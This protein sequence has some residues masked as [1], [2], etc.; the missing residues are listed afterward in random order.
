MKVVVTGAAGFIGTH[1]VAGLLQRDGVDVVG[2]DSFTDYYD[3]KIKEARVE[4]LASP[5]FTFHAEDLLEA[6]LARVFGDASVILHLAGQAGVRPSWG[7]DFRSYTDRNILATQRLLEFVHQVHPVD[8][9]VYAS[10]SSV[11][12]NADGYP[13]TEAALPRPFSPYGVTKLAAEHLCGLYAENYDVPTVSL[14]YFT[15]YGPGQRPDMAFTRFIRAVQDDEEI[16]VNGDGS[17]IRDFTYVGDVVR[18]NIAAAFAP[19]L[20]PGRV[21]NVCGG[22]PVTLTAVLDTLRDIAGKPLRITHTGEKAGDVFQ[23]GGSS[24]AARDALGWSPRTDLASG[25]R[26]QW[27]AAKD[28]FAG[29]TT[30][31]KDDSCLS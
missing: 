15:V 11:Y 29:V 19:N 25:L 12:G 1:L 10:S 30:V 3:P 31:G 8:R 22:S 4:R 17:Q 26:A 20:T 7:A 27:Q 9:F 23:T 13:V 16:T 28:E 21:F 14:R 5:R 24:E 2:I 6:D 18:A